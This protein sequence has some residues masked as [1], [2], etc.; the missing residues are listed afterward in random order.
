MNSP[1]KILSRAVLGVCL[2]SGVVAVN[3]RAGAPKND[4]PKTTKAPAQ[5]EAADVP[6][7]KHDPKNPAEPQAGFVKRHEGFL[8]DL[9]AKN[10]KVGVLFVGDSITDGWRGG[11]KE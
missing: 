11:G 2:V 4:A 10:G 9:A 7:P 8:K 1:W 6:N 5:H 3:V